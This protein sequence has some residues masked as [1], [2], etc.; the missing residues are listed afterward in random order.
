LF[1]ALNAR[2]YHDLQP[3][4]QDAIKVSSQ[5]QAKTRKAP[6]SS[7]RVEESMLRYFAIG[8]LVILAAALFIVA[9]STVTRAEAGAS[10]SAASKNTRASQLASHQSNHQNVGITEYSSSSARNR[11]R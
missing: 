11:S 3:K 5:R 10:A 7:D 9:V 8:K 2:G 1:V 4:Q 6:L